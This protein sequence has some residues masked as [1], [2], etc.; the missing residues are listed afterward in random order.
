V[1]YLQFSRSAIVRGISTAIFALFVAAPA[2]AQMIDSVKRIDLPV[3]RSHVITIAG[4]V[5]KIAVANDLIADVTAMSANDVLVNAKA[6][7][8]T[9][10]LIWPITGTVQHYRVL[11]HSPADRKQILIGVKFA[12]VRKNFLLNLGV[13]GLYN[14]RNVRAGSGDFR[15]N[16]NIDP[17][18]GKPLIPGSTQFLTVLS[19]FG[20]RDFVALIRAE[21]ERGNAEILAEP[22]IMAGNKDTA[23]FLAGGEIPVPVP[24]QGA[25]GGSFITIQYREFGVRLRFAG[26]IISDSLIKL[27][28]RPEVSDLD[29]ANAITI[30]GFRIPALRTR[31]VESTLDIKRD[32]SLII[33]GMFNTQREQVRNGI[34]LLMDI[35]ILGNLFSSTRWQRNET[36]L[37]VVVTPMVI[38]P[39]NPRAIDVLTFPTDT[40]R[41]AMKAIKK[42]RKDEQK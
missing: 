2:Q 10:L 31:Y 30:S 40:T 23:S 6:T 25:G 38:D 28:I 36:E 24:Q 26:E 20:T 12:E 7:G 15:N 1:I 16:A 14:G 3:G 22:S 27:K 5:S 37:I 4:G 34:P 11:V 32:Q 29:F 19:D 18:T 42:G 13:S 35:P 41:P 8:E 39:L 21:E 33:S 9:D 17:A